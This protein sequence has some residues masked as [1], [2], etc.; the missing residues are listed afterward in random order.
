MKI[1]T[2]YHN[3][4][5]DND[6][7][8]PKDNDEI[9][10][11]IQDTLKS[12]PAFKILYNEPL[13]DKT[14]D[15]TLNFADQKKHFVIL[16]TGGSNLGARA[17]INILQGKEKKDIFFFDNIDP[18]N[19][20]NSIKKI[21]LDNTGFIIISKS[22]STP[23]TISQFSALIEIFE[24]KNSLNNFY[25]NILVITEDKPSP[26]SNIAYS[27]KCLMMKHQKDIGGRFSIFSNVGMVPAI[28]AGL[29]VKKVHKGA[30]LEIENQSK[31]D[32]LKIAQYFR[33]HNNVLNINNSVV[34]TYSDALFFFGKW[35]LQLWAESLGKK[36]KGITPIHAVGTTD[37]HSQLQLYLDGP[38]DKFFTF[39]TTDHAN[40]GLKLH[41]RT[42]NENKLKYL[43]NK[44]MGDLMQAEQKA[45]I[46]TF[47]QN[48]FSLREI[49]LYSIDELSIGSLMAFSIM[50]TIATCIYF[51][52]DPFNQPAVEQGKILTKKYLS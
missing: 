45:T 6:L 7:M 47:K 48:K 32:F 37:Q 40:K 17:L 34:M 41:Q 26:L 24:Q 43:Y 1:K 8:L 18:L 11:R 13:L 49:N 3:V 10:K 51:D 21:D 36:N 31:N 46:D 29:D 9:L 52:V 12:L 14:I 44:T 35:Y 28:I 2:N 33:Y 23:E 15:L 50:E 16:G 19:F 20:E 4:N 42:M 5:F 30:L 25:K 38:K 22:G 39:I 27:N